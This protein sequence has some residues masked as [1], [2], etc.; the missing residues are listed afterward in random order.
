MEGP[1]KIMENLCQTSRYRERDSNST[2]LPPHDPARYDGDN[3]EDKYSCSSEQKL[4][5]I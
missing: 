1:S 2:A 3:E 4:C 5:L